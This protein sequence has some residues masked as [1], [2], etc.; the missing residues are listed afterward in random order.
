[1]N[2]LAEVLSSKTRADFFHLLF[3]I[4]ENRLHLREIQRKSGRSLS[5]IQK[6]ASKLTS[7]QLLN[8]EINGNRVYYSANKQHPLYTTIHDLVL[9]TSG[10]VD[11]FEILQ[12]HKSID[13]AFIFGSFANGNSTSVSDVDLFIIGSISLR[14]LSNSIAKISEVISREVNPFVIS[15]DEYINRLK[16]ND[17]FI[18]SVCTSQRIMI[19]GSI[20]ELRRLEK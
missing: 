14:E 4:Y 20:Y 2:I 12:H 11:N 1:M 17:H 18:S 7:L 15:I 5:S 9:K 16:T 10:L 13:F 8:R 3:G 6:E 19:K